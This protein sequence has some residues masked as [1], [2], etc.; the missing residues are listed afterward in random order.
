MAE[1]N[2]IIADKNRK[3]AF[4]EGMVEIL[5]AQ[6]RYLEKTDSQVNLSSWGTNI[7]GYS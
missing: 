5:S 7:N 2:E 3:I 6:I 4:C 1:L